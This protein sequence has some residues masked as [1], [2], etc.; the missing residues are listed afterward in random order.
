[1]TQLLL[2]LRVYATGSFLISAGDFSGVSTTSAHYIVHRVSEAIARL[3]PLYI[4]FPN[5]EEE[6]RKE[7]R[8]FY[9]IARFPRVI[10]CIDCTHI[11]VQSFGGEDAEL[12]RNRKGYFSINAQV[13]CNSNLQITDIVARWQGSVH[14][15]TIF[16]NSR[17][18]ANFENGAYDNGFLLGDSAYPS[19]QYLLT[20]LITT[21]I[22]AERL[23]NESHIRTRNIIKRLFGV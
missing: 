3:R 5:T 21:Q 11:R 18:K 17:L 10:G 22:A 8:Q 6:I 1:M 16:N 2:T 14:D 15:S 4:H 13:T 23:Y 19:K 20:L 12:F 9:N 7:Q